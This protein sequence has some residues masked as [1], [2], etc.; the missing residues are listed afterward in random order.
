[1]NFVIMQVKIPPA[2][3]GCIHERQPHGHLKPTG[4]K[5][6]EAVRRD[7]AAA[8]HSSTAWTHISV[9]IN[10]VI[11]QIAPIGG[12][13][14][15]SKTRAPCSSRVPLKGFVAMHPTEVRRCI[16]IIFCLSKQSTIV[17]IETGTPPASEHGC[18]SS[19]QNLRG[20]GAFCSGNLPTS[21]GLNS[22][23]VKLFHR[24]KSP[25]MRREIHCKGSC[26]LSST[27]C[28]VYAFF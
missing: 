12:K 18:F 16:Q 6:Q 8:T 20:D 14:S 7:P 25:T 17:I 19:M 4:Q 10:G 9:A 5:L 3:L 22:A 1:M 15:P 23:V 13:Y 26:M 2:R 24:A 27:F 21:G 11:N 28:K